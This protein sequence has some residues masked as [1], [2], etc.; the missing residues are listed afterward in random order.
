VQLQ[1]LGSASVMSIVTAVGNMWF[2]NELSG[3]LAP[4][5]IQAIFRSSDAIKTL[6]TAELQRMVRGRFV[7]SFNLQMHIVLGFAVTGVFNALFMWQRNRVRI[8]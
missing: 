2:R 5:Q 6:L 4:E 3:I 7:E 1:F 8:L